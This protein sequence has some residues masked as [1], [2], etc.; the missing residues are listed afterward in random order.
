[1]LGY[2]FRRILL[3]IPTLVVVSLISFLVI[4]L[5]EGDYI[6]SYVASLRQSGADV[7]EEAIETLRHRYGLDQPLFVRYYK[8]IGG[9]VLQGDW[10]HSFAYAKPVKELIGERMLLTLSLAMGSMLLTWIVGLPI[11]VYSAVKQYSVGDYVASFLGFVGVA[12]PGFLIALIVMY[13]AFKWT[14]YVVG[15]LFSPEY[16]QAAWSVGRVLDLLKRLWVPALIVGLSG[17]AGTIRTT[18]A[19]LL[20]EL[21]RPYVVTARSKG[22]SE[23]RLIIKYPVRMIMNPF[24]SGLA[25]LLP[26]LI[27]SGTIV[28]VVLSLPTTGPMYLSALQQQ[29]S[30]LAGSFVFLLSGLTLIGTLISDILLAWVDP[31]IRME[32]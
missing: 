26:N 30:Y 28:A 14:G 11:G 27:S 13:L 31:R 20:D 17:V 7:S 8:W 10:G 6:D 29:D 32:A 18:R 2:I 1:M 24:V 25:F 9:I 12:V 4:D 16:V 23:R 21:H 3:M 22:L 19:N 15:G 5:P